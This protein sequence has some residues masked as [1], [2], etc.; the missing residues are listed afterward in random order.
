MSDPAFQ[1]GKEGDAPYRSTRGQKP[2]R[3]RFHQPSHRAI[4]DQKVKPDEPERE[5][6]LTGGITDS[7][8]M[9]CSEGRQW[10]L[11][12]ENHEHEKHAVDEHRVFDEKPLPAKVLN[13][14]VGQPDLGTDVE[15]ET[16][17]CQHEV[18]H[19]SHAF[20]ARNAR[21]VSRSSA[22]CN[23]CLIISFKSGDCAA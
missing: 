20:P 1:P 11:M 6:S 18:L 4:K 10:A 15:N 23:T 5:E 3:W 13:N 19:Y 21:S 2:F 12:E 8:Y 9:L 14:V 22:D 16:Q 7:G 17:P